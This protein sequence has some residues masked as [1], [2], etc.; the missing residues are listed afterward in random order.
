[1]LRLLSIAAVL[2][3]LLPGQPAKAG[4]LQTFK[5]PVGLSFSFPQ[6]WRIQELESG[7]LLIPAG[8]AMV[9]EVPKEFVFVGGESVPAGTPVDHPEVLEFLESQVRAQFPGAKP[10][11]G[12][13]YVQTGIGKGACI[14]FTDKAD[15]QHRAYV[16]MYQ[17]LGI[18]AIHAGTK[19]NGARNK[20]ALAVFQSLGGS[21]VEDPELFGTWYRSET[22][23]T[24]ITT[25]A[26]ANDYSNA[27]S[28]VSSTTYSTYLFEGGNRVYHQVGGRIHIDPGQGAMGSVANAEDSENAPYAGT[29]AVHGNSLTILWENGEEETFEYNVFET[30]DGPALKL[31]PEGASK[32]LFHRRQD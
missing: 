32:P 15:T 16:V 4:P 13:N 21:L 27:G 7:Q 24:D 14:V 28:Y 3:L 10:K 8:V 19:A 1:M 9:G 25:D 12:V 6:D 26:Q 20:E 29:Y 22:Q 30:N 31:L 18:Y 11:E 23:S 5:H 2:A 17:G